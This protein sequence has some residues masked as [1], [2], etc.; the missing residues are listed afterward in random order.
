LGDFAGAD[1]NYVGKVSD[2]DFAVA[3]LASASGTHDRFDDL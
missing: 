2:K 1:A 3:K